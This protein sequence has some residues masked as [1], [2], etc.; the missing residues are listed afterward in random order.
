M[1]GVSAMLAVLHVGRIG[2]GRRG[3]A[4]LRIDRLSN[5]NRSCAYAES[6]K[7]QEAG[8]AYL[9]LASRPLLSGRGADQ[10]G[11]ASLQPDERHRN[12]RAKL[13]AP[14]RAAAGRKATWV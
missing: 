9:A 5:V 1:S 8:Q 6:R 13:Q 7:P 4:H 3:N 2:R 10:V 12:S 11:L 14:R